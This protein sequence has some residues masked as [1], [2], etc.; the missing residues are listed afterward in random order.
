[1]GDG[2]GVGEVFLG[3]GLGDAV[4]ACSGSQDELPAGVAAA[5]AAV[6]AVAA[7][8]LP[9]AAAS[10]TLPVVKVTAVRRA[11]AE[12]MQRLHS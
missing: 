5:A 9:E 11:R 3:V 2:V 1:V 4:A 6:P 12:G 7:R 10:R 8:M